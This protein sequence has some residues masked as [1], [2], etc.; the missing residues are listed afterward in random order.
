M[1]KEERM[2]V[3]SEEYGE[4]VDLQLEDYREGGAVDEL[5]GLEEME[6]AEE[7][8]VGSTDDYEHDPVSIYMRKISAT[9]LL[10]KKGEIELAR[11]IEEGMERLCG[12]LSGLPCFLDKLVALGRQVDKAEISLADLVRSDRDEFSEE[13]LLAERQRFSEI[14][15][16][17][18]G[19]L[20]GRRRLLNAETRGKSDRARQLEENK[21]KILLKVSEL[22]LKDK[23]VIGFAEELKELEGCLK[24]PKGREEMQRMTGLQV[25]EMK[26][27][28]REVEEAETEIS[29]AKGK[30][31]EA[32]LRLVISVAK[33]YI[34]MGLSMGDLIQEGNIGLMRAVDRFE[35]KKG[36]KFSTYATWWI[37]QAIGR[38][39]ADHART[40]RIPVHMID[41]M[42]RVNKVIREYV[43]EHGTEPGTHEIAKRLRM[44]EE[45]VREVM[46]I[47]PEPV[48]IDTPVGGEEDSAL[49][50][51][52]VDS[53][54]PSPLE[55]IMQE[56]LREHID[57]ILCLLPPREELIIRKRF[58]IGDGS[59]YTLEEIGADFDVTRERV[60]QMQ[61]GALK[62]LKAIL[63]CWVISSRLSSDEVDARP[64]YAGCR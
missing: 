43:Q 11:Q 10:R 48:S 16:S 2:R 1:E 29:E 24:S 7:E 19:L 52:I 40:I 34:G 42:G 45:K 39:L 50:D 12:A 53:T 18:Q 17:L 51:F 22:G 5:L 38:A 14:I 33:R 49:K 61:M 37:R 64:A 41:S 20:A 9:P 36:Y 28:M 63:S 59:P 23:V 58:G 25:R 56:D 13:H 30:L 46:K 62:K 6:P 35:Y 15:K 32:N 54:T 60:R 27:V 8:A 31:I 21:K 26:E 57:R 4:T 3:L 55:L 47:S 44:P